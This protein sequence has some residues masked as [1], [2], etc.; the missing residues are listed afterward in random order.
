M[1]NIVD[2][3]ATSSLVDMQWVQH[4]KGVLSVVDD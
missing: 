3:N 1:V 4:K 2:H